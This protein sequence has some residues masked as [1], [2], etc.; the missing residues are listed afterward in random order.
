VNH[1]RD[2]DSKYGDLLEN[3]SSQTYDLSGGLNRSFGSSP[4]GRLLKRLWRLMV[5]GYCRKVWIDLY[6]RGII[7]RDEMLRRTEECS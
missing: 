1:I 4:G 3:A 2:L 7:S 5:L 6:C